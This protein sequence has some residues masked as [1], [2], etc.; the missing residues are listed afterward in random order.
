MEKNPIEE[1]IKIFSS[2]PFNR[3]LG[4]TVDAIEEDKIIMS[5]EMKADLIGNVMQGI[6]HG[7]V[8][9]SV[10]DMAGGVAAMTA[11]VRKQSHKS[12]EELESILGKASTI[13]LHI[14][15]LFPGKGKRFIATSYVMR[16]GNKI[17]FTRTEL[18][19]DE[20]ILIATGA[21]TYLVG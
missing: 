9:S 4:L 21:G 18:H 3:M 19:N 14:N 5:F 16:S 6:L 20:N 11:A 10:I 15:Y 7:G 12:R 13:N 17:T 1:L 2:L 8:I